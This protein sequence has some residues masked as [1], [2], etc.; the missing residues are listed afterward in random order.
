[1]NDLERA[2]RLP[3]TRAWLVSELSRIRGLL[4]EA[5]EGMRGTDIL[6][7]GAAVSLLTEVI[8][9]VAGLPTPNE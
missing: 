3:V 1:M 2:G 7:P 8:R 4:M 5:R 6:D 9:K